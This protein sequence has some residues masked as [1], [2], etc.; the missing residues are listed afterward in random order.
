MARPKTTDYPRA[1]ML[2]VPHLTHMGYGCNAKGRT[3]KVS[4]DNKG[5]LPYDIGTGGRES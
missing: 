2:S 3:L 4:A 1:K 5:E